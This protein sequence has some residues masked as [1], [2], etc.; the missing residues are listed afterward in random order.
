[1]GWT[2]FHPSKM[3]GLCEVGVTYRNGAMWLDWRESLSQKVKLFMRK[4][5]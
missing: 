1:L 2:W 3:V 5:F 4:C